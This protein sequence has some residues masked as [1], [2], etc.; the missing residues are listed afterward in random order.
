M[1]TNHTRDAVVTVWVGT[2]DD[3]MS[4]ARFMKSALRQHRDAIEHELRASDRRSDS[5]LAR[6]NE[7]FEVQAQATDRLDGTTHRGS[8]EQVLAAVRPQDMAELSMHC[9]QY[10]ARG[11]RRV[12]LGFNRYGLHCRVEAEEQVWA[13]QMRQELVREARRTEPWWARVTRVPGGVLAVLALLAALIA[14]CTTVASRLNLG[15]PDWVPIAVAIILANLYNVP[16]LN[17]RLMPRFQLLE[18]GQRSTGSW[19][20]GGLLAFLVTTGLGLFVAWLIPT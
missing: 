19:L 14:I 20:L 18:D 3:V 12:R 13:S 5:E 2:R 8:L 9:P 4:L 16:A 15:G 7:D 17:R 11:S 6:L 1:Q 10:F